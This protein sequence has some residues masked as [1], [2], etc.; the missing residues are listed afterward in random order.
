MRI[1][2][3]TNACVRLYDAY[4]AQPLK[5]LG[6]AIKSIKLKSAIWQIIVIKQIVT[7]V[8]RSSVLERVQYLYDQFA[9]KVGV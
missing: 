8:S 3:N 5:N 9:N 1:P 6:S 7:L 2:V 4:G